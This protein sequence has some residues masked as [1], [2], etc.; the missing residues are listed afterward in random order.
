MKATQVTD[1]IYRL[2]ASIG[3]GILFESMWPLSTWMTMNSYLVKGTSAALIDGVCGWDGVPETLHRQMEELSTSVK[4]IRYVVLNHLEPDH[5]GWLAPFREII[6]DFEIVATP[7]GIEL[8]KE[9]FG[10]TSN[11]RAVTSG[12]RIPLGGGRELVFEE[13]PHVHWPETMVT[14]EA[15]TGTLF[16][17]DAFGSFGYTGD[18]PYDDQLTAE[19]LA[20]F[21]YEALRYY[22]NIIAAFSGF[23]NKALDKLESLDIRTVASAHGVVWRKDPRRIIELYR[24]FA[25]NMTD[26]GPE[27]TLVWGSMYGNTERAV[28][29]AVEGAHSENVNVHVHRVPQEHVSYI[30]ASAWRSK[31]LI[32]GAPTYEYRMFPPLAHVVDDFGRKKVMKRTVLPFG[33]YGWSG[34]AQIELRKLASTLQWEI[35]EPVEFRGAPGEEELELVRHRSGELARRVK[36]AAGLRAAS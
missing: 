22:A 21:E 36:E 9:L 16:S 13:I 5:T 14:Y 19:E 28:R 33:S 2:F 6:P 15:G 17:G 31:G 27:I 30:L 25:R 7:K 32:L 3:E 24:R 12:D 1:G 35:L 11:L 4:D 18:F 23:V 10:I 8:V 26:P 20:F 29:Y 34:G